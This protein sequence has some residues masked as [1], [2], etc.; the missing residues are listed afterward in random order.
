MKGLY[1]IF[2]LIFPL[3]ITGCEEEIEWNIKKDNTDKMV[4]DGILTNENKIQ[5]ISIT[6]TIQELN[7]PKRPYSGLMVS[8]TD[9]I[10]DYPF[11][12]DTNNPGSYLSEPFRAVAGRV[13]ELT[14]QT[15]SVTYNAKARAVAVTPLKEISIEKDNDS[16]FYTYSHIEDL[17]PSMIEVFYDWHSDTSFC[18]EY[19]YSKAAETYYSLNNIDVSKAFSPEKLKIKFPSGTIISRKKYSLSDEHHDFLRSL[20]METEWRGGVF[21]EQQGN[22]ETNMTNGALGFFAVCMVVSDTT[23]VK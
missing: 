19:G 10:R 15:D 11:K 7:A 14:I 20:L 6:H 17:K 21:D 22:V 12:E 2:I 8:V 13:Y 18:R 23:L 3:L 9:N 5:T 1:A 4:V 16:N